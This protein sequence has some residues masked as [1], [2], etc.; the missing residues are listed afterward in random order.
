MASLIQKK[1]DAGPNM[2]THKCEKQVKT[3]IVSQTGK[4]YLSSSSHGGVL[5]V[6]AEVSPLI[7]SAGVIAWRPAQ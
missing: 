3:E 2:G 6:G 5:R 4:G 7:L 1:P